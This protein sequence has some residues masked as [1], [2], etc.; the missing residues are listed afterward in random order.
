MTTEDGKSRSQGI[1]AKSIGE[2]C[3]RA[4]AQGQTA[5]PRQKA[6]PKEVDSKVHMPNNNSTS[7]HN[8]CYSR[9]TSKMPANWYG[10][11]LHIHH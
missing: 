8:Q 4:N 6:K 9:D 11:D 5:V 2:D 10:G 1:Y 3:H 7:V